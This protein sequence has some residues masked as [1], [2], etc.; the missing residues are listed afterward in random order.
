[1]NVMEQMRQAFEMGGRQVFG[2][3]YEKNGVTVIPVARVFGGGGGGEGTP[4]GGEPA[5]GGGLGFNARPAGAFV[6][7][8]DDVRW[9]PAVDVNRIVLGAQLVAIAALLTVRSI[10]KA[11]ARRR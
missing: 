5:S 6:V 2:Q 8:G 4:E 1:M 3:P 7:I 9:Q 10:V 11:R